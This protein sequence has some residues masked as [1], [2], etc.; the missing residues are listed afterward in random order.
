MGLKTIQSPS[1]KVLQNHSNQI[2]DVNRAVSI[3][4]RFVCDVT[5][6]QYKLLSRLHDALNEMI[7]VHLYNLCKND[8]NMIA[9]SYVAEHE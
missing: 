3:L 6:T 7:T 5:E 1:E 2:S 4:S 9:C 8:E